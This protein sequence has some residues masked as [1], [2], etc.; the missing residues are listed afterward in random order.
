MMW[1]SHMKRIREWKCPLMQILLDME[2]S[3]LER[4]AD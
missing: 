2:G 4:L 1:S 3:A